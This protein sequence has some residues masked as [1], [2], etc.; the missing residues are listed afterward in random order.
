MYEEVYRGDD[1][2]TFMLRSLKNNSEGGNEVQIE[3]RIEEQGEENKL[4]DFL[5]ELKKFFEEKNSNP[6]N[7]DIW[8]SIYGQVTLEFTLPFLKFILVHELKITID[9]N[10]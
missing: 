1:Q 2:A 6:G 7:Y 5:S 9:A 3:I 4:E 10:D 8:I